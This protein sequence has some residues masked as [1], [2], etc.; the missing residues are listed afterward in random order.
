MY[1]FRCQYCGR[2]NTDVLCQGCGNNGAFELMDRVCLRVSDDEWD[3]A[4]K[5]WRGDYI[6]LITIPPDLFVSSISL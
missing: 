3:K 4:V 2:L 6:K 5:A 1:K